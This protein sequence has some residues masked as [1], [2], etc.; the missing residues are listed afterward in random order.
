MVHG[1]RARRAAL[2]HGAARPRADR[3]HGQRHVRTGGDAGRH[4][5]AGRSRHPRIDAGSGLRIVALR[6]RVLHGAR[7]Q[8][9]GEPRRA[10]PRGRRPARR[11][12][13]AAGRHPGGHH[14]RRRPHPLRARRAAV[15][16]HRRCVHAVAG[17]EPRLAR[18][19]DP[20]HQPGRHLARREPLR[21]TR[22]LV[23][24]PQP[25]GLRLASRDRRD[26][27]PRSTA[28]PATT[29]ST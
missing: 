23:R 17:A 15:R 4:V 3:E 13:R 27:G 11:A 29:R 14:P 25:P 12:R 28:R 19:Q 9:R 10:L 18:R 16:E 6:L 7:R 26:C 2:R 24:P 20:A 8:R 1:V 5:R 21:L 22:V